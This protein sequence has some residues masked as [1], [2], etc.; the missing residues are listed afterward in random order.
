MLGRATDTGKERISLGG[1][2]AVFPTLAKD[3]ARAGTEFEDEP[4]CAG[5]VGPEE[6]SV[7]V[8]IT[9]V[10]TEGEEESVLLSVQRAGAD[11][12]TP[13]ETGANET[14]ADDVTA[15]SETEKAEEGG[16]PAMA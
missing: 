12:P 5:A 13:E 9:G 1:R 11:E 15:T 7:G 6:V 3:F 14:E 2:A 10:E 16:T 4:V 8:E